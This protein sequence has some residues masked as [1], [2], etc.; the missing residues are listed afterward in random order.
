L[1]LGRAWQLAVVEVDPTFILAVEAA[2]VAVGEEV[3]AEED[4]EAVV[5]APDKATPY[6]F[7]PEF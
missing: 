7:R 4:T 2:L 1:L 5:V 3:A 6:F